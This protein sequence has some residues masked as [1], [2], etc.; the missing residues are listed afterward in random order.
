M[1]IGSILL[2]I[3]IYFMLYSSFFFLILYFKKKDKLIDPKSK[4]FPLVSIIIPVYER[5]KK[6]YLKKAINSCLTLDYPKKEIILAWN[7]PKNELYNVCK[8]F[9][10]WGIKFVETEKRG[11]AAGLNKALEVVNG[12]FFVCLDADSFFH[13]NAIRNMIGYFKDEKV[14]AVTSSIKIYK[15]KTFFQKIQWVEYI[16]AIYLRKLFSIIDALY[17]V[18]GPGGMYRTNLIKKLGGFDEGNLTEDMEIAFRILNSGYKVKN[19]INSYVGTIAPEKFKELLKQRVRWYAG[20]CDNLK[21]YKN[22]LLNPN[23]GMLGMF[24]LP[25]SIIWIGIVIYALTYLAVRF[26]LN[27]LTNLNILLI[28]IDFKTFFK[29]LLRSIH[30]QPTFLTWFAVILSLLGI[31]S[32]YIGLK[33]SNEEIKIKKRYDYYIGYFLIYSILLGIFWISALTYF[34]TKNKFGGIW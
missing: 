18:P 4:N 3:L 9:K 32:I 30:F 10:K 11:K 25:F 5:D 1:E 16:F 21:N 13:K 6:I 7:G 2:L 22:L 12:K 33:M 8:S 28:G 31:L 15:P 17:V 23:S 14:G 20:F 27:S 24:V 29:I 26:I 19:S 34:F